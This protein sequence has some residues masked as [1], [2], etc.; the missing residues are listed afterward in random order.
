MLSS[1]P[2]PV[3]FEKCIQDLITEAQ[4]AKSDFNNFAH[5]KQKSSSYQ[6]TASKKLIVQVLKSF[7]SETSKI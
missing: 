2:Q 6:K 7:D 1:T 4:F 5:D 3:N